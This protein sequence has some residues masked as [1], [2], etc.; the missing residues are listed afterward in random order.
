MLNSEKNDKEHIQPAKYPVLLPK[1][2]KHH[3]PIS[4]GMTWV[5]ALVQ[6]WLECST[7]VTDLRTSIRCLLSFFHAT[8]SL[9]PGW[10]HTSILDT[11]NYFLPCSCHTPPSTT[12]FKYV[13]RFPSPEGSVYPFQLLLLQAAALCPQKRFS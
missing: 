12:T 3:F 13:K 1:E 5:Q 11:L 8:H 9:S 6:A 7:S 10:A 4:D 2:F